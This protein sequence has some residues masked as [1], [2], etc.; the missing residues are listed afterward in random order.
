M[1]RR[2]DNSQSLSHESISQEYNY[3]HNFEVRESERHEA[4]MEEITNAHRDFVG[5]SDGKRPLGTP[6]RD[7]RI[8]LNW[9]VG[10]KK[11]RGRGSD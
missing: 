5:K 4:R 10:K 1:A 3:R 9:I 8:K 7:C 2:S 6:R 11:V